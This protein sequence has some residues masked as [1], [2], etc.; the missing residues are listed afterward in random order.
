MRERVTRG[1]SFAIGVAGLLAL[2]P[3]R[4]ARPPSPI[5]VRMP[6][7]ISVA[8]PRPVLLPTVVAAVPEP[9]LAGCPTPPLDDDAAPIGR[10]AAR[11]EQPA[12]YGDPAPELAV[13]ASAT[14]GVI[15]LVDRR[16]GAVY[17]STDDG[18]RFTRVFRRHT[19]DAIAVDDRGRIYAV[20]ADGLFVRDPDGRERRTSVACT[21]ETCVDRLVAIPGGVAWIHDRAIRTSVDGGRRWRTVDDDDALELA[22]RDHLFALDGRLWGTTHISEDCGW[23]ADQVTSI[24]SATGGYE[25]R[26]FD[27]GETAPALEL[28]DDRGASW[29]YRAVRTPAHDVVALRMAQLDPTV[30][31]RALRV[32]NGTLVEVCGDR[33]RAVAHAFRA[34]RVDAVDA[35]GRPLYVRGDA[36]DRWS[37]TFGWRVL[38]ETPDD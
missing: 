18:R 26:S 9:P 6:V 27:N 16:R 30:G 36:L 12:S 8:T 37:P 14:L 28:A 24:D 7:A 38:F 5:V 15:A 33:G 32:D 29:R 35:A 4:P 34:D 21:A 1:V 3:P 31:G 2:G 10:A 13:A 23:D 17:A 22:G 19:A 20:G 25:D 11:D